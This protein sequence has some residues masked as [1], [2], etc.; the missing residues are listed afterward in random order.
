LASTIDLVPTILA[1]C[2][3]QAPA[4]LPGVNLLSETRSEAFGEIFQHDVADIDDP[5]ASLQYRWRID[6]DWKLIL[7][8]DGDNAELY[9]LKI[10]PL[11][12][13]NLAAKNADRV[14]Q[15]TGKLNEWWPITN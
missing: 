7:P 13:E 9:N 8:K 3:F 4:N 15:M 2:G 10:D 14:R 12:N 5:R 1:V 11:E 6:G